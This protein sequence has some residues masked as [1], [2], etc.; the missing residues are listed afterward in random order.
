MGELKLDTIT[1]YSEA[2]QVYQKAGKMP[3][4]LE[5]RTKIACNPAVIVVFW[6]NALN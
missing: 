3:P 1:S 5:R 6:I 4:L 2:N